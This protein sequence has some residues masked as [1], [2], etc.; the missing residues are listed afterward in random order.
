[1]MFVDTI[2]TRSLS[3]SCCTFKNNELFT[4]LP[5]ALEDDLNS[6]KGHEQSGTACWFV[7]DRLDLV[8]WLR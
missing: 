1:M 8:S 2:V 3:H 4:K 5:T 6:D 7:Q